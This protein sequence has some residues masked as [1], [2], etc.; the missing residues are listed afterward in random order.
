MRHAVDLNG[1]SRRYSTRHFPVYDDKLTGFAG[2]YTDVTAEWQPTRN[3]S[4]LEGRLEDVIRSTSDW[5]WE[6]DA[7]FNLTF[8]SPR[9]VEAL[10]VLPPGLIGK[11]LFSLG[12]FENHPPEEFALPD[13]LRKL[14]PFRGRT[15]LLPDSKGAVR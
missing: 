13:F 14:M 11:H 9:I 10:E 5:V 4:R 2:V 3:A 1:G 7:N 8:V 15:F 6:T 12:R